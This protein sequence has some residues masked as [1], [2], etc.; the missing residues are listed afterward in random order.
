M[1]YTAVVLFILQYL[2]KAE[3]QKITLWRRCQQQCPPIISLGIAKSDFVHSLA[4]QRE[5]NFTEMYLFLSSAEVLGRCL[6]SWVQQKR[7]S[8]M[9]EHPR[10]AICR[11]V[12]WYCGYVYTWKLWI[13]RIGFY[14]Q[15]RRN[16]E[17]I[18]TFRIKY[19]PGLWKV[20]GINVK[21]ITGCHL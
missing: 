6:I 5:H 3:Y 14:R 18:V 2:M 9:P 15:K 4:F 16:V 1:R 12:T 19:S 7:V 11:F 21:R 20:L 13:L 17:E 8:L 10:S